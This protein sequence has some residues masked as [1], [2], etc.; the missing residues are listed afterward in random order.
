MPVFRMELSGDL[1]VNAPNFQ[2]RG[3]T[4]E[5]NICFSSEEIKNSFAMDENSKVTGEQKDLMRSEDS[6]IIESR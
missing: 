1:Y 5:G 3:T 2:L 6:D 4:V